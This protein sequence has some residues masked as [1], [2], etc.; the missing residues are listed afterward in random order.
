GV[1]ALSGIDMNLTTFAFPTTIRFGPGALRELPDM[2]ARLRIEHPLL[3][4]DAGLART[5]IFD[6]VMKLGPR[7]VVFS[8]VAPNPTE[9]NVIDGVAAYREGLCDGIIGL[10]GG[11]P[12]D[13]AKAIRLK[14]THELP[15]AEYDDLIDGGNKITANLPPYIAIATTS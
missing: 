14:V 11:S 8:R 5:A 3:V 15:L 7:A 9:Q 6:R 13:A 4:T 1:G 10:G 2:L 12:L